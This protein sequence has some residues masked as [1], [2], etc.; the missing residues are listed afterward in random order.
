MRRHL[1]SILALWAVSAA[2]GTP[3]RFL[4][5]G[6]PCQLPFMYQGASH[7][8]CLLWTDGQDWCPGLDGHWGICRCG[9][10]KQA[11]ARNWWAIFP[12]PI[13]RCAALRLDPPLPLATS[14]LLRIRW[15]PR[16]TAPKRAI[17]RPATPAPSAA[18][19]PTP[20]SIPSRSRP[21]TAGI[22][23]ARHSA[24]SRQGRGSS[25]ASLP[26]LGLQM[27]VVVRARE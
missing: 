6:G 25:R 16:W 8:D 26:D 22:T 17:G 21:A 2:E 12:P 5:S 4:A 10:S 9:E 11:R 3:R 19:T 20:A 1:A 24:G 13:L 23:A 7:T 15:L 18:S 14:L 27:G